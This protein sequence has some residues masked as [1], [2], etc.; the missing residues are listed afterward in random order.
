M[1]KKLRE[2]ENLLKQQNPSGLGTEFKR[3]IEFIFS[4]KL[5]QPESI[6]CLLY[7]SPSPRDS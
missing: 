1:D 4:E 3:Q 2:I 7:T 6:N 5:G